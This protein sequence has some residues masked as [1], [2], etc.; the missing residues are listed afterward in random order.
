[1]PYPIRMAIL[2]PMLVMGCASE[3]KTASTAP[4]APSDLVAVLRDKAAHVCN[5]STAA[6]LAARGVTASA[7]A[8][9]YYIPLSSGGRES[10]RRIGSQAWI[11]L[12]GQPGSVVIDLNLDCKLLQIYTRDGASL[13]R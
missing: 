4:A 3:P 2:L 8:T 5:E 7:I 10:A 9:G 6:A 13:P 1:M 12:A 11:G